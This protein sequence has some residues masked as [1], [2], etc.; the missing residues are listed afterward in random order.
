MKHDAAPGADPEWRVSCVLPAFNEHQVIAQVVGR[1][2][3]AL[4]SLCAAFEIVVV[5]DGSDDG[6]AGVLDGMDEPWLRV[7]HF[8]ENRGYGWA[9]RA[10]FAAAALPL[11]F[12]MDSDDQF[13]P[14]DLARLLPLLAEADVVVGCRDVR[15]DGVLRSSLSAGYNRLVRSLLGIR[16]RDVN[17]AFK[18]MRRDTLARLDLVSDSYTINAELLMRAAQAGVDVRE[19]PVSHAPRSTGRSKVGVM[20]IPLAWMRLVALRRAH[21]GN[22]A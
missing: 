16:V 12:F 3:A 11:V 7:I 8:P 5:D 6:T 9:L 1:T 2:A 21:R 22:S 4:A 13:D 18:L 20:D 14:L 15:R 17:C 19:V 10:G